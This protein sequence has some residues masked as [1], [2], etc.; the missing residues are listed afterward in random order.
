VRRRP[1]LEDHVRA[2]QARHEAK[3]KTTSRWIN[4]TR[5]INGWSA[6]TYKADGWYFMLDGEFPERYR[7][8]KT[9]SE[10]AARTLAYQTA[11]RIG[12]PHRSLAVVAKNP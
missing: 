2:A 8:P 11:R 3:T 1:K 9:R 5:W 7:G 10:R 4:H 6:R 12:P